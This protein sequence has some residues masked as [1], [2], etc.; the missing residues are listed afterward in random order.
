MQLAATIEAYASE[1]TGRAGSRLGATRQPP[2]DFGKHWHR[3]PH[4]LVARRE[5]CL[6]C[7]GVGFVVAPP[8][9][10]FLVVGQGCHASK[11]FH[12]SRHRSHRAR[13]ICRTNLLA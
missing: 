9:L 6:K 4:R 2:A 13:F 5:P 1:L 8:E 10:T 12:N 11:W 3:G 7:T